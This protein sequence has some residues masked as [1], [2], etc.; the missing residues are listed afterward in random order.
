M[1]R[2]IIC[3]GK[4]I[5]SF[6][7][8]FRQCFSE[9]CL[10]YYSDSQF[11]VKDVSLF[12]NVDVIIF[13]DDPFDFFRLKLLLRLERC[14]PHV[15]CGLLSFLSFNDLSPLPDLYDFSLPYPPTNTDLIS[16]KTRF[17]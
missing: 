2:H 9:H 12:Q 6:D 10:L 11:C 16:I 15:I 17:L 3:I 7:L 8:L 13:L 14:F 1:Q 5:A 4:N